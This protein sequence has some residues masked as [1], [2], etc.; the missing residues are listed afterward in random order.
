MEAVA[1][2]G[3]AVKNFSETFAGVQVHFYVLRLKQSFLVWIG[4]DATFSTLAVA[5]NTRF[6]SVLQLGTDRGWGC[7][8]SD[9]HLLGNS[10]V[11]SFP[12]QFFPAL[13]TC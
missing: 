8:T 4:T 2:T 10:I 11:V 3:V 12:A 13:I 5:M 1:E 9:H 6:V 7:S